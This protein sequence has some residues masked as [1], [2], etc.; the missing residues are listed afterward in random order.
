M[1]RPP[2]TAG[3]PGGACAS[4]ADCTMGDNGRCL[5][6]RIG[7]YCNYDE[8]FEDSDCPTGQLCACDIGPGYQN[9]CIEAGC[10]TNGDCPGSHTCASSLS[11][12]G[13]YFPP[14]GYYCHTDADA[15]TLDADCAAMGAGASCRYNDFGP[16]MGRWTCSSSM[17][18]G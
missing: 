11:S 9:I 4:D 3:G 14:M 12:C 5:F 7:A 18:A 17:C 1:G 10:L 15:C 2:G 6:G 13:T 16:D 8:C